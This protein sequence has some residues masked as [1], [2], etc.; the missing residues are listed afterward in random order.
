MIT[1]TAQS[2][3]RDVRYALRVLARAP[4]FTAVAI[5][6]LAIAVAV[7]TASFSV[8]NSLLF[9][10]LP[11][12]RDRDGLISIFTGSSSSAGDV[13]VG[14]SD[15]EDLVAYRRWAAGLRG[16]A[17]A[18]LTQVSVSTAAG[19]QYQ[20]AAAVTGNY[21]VVLG[22]VPLAGRFPAAAST[23]AGE[24]DEAN[25]EHPVVVVSHH[26]WQREL[27]GR[28]SAIGST[29]SVNAHPVT[30]IGVAPPG[31]SGT[32]AGGLLP[33][34]SS[35][36]ELWFPLSTWRDIRPAGSADPLGTERQLMVVA[37][38]D[39]PISMADARGTVANAVRHSAI[40]RPR[41]RAGAFA[42]V[43]PIGQGPNES[44]AERAL[45]ILGIMIV[46]V[47]LLV[48]ACANVGVLLLTRAVHR[49]REIAL[50]VAL[51]ASRPQLL[52][53]L[54]TESGLIAV[55]AGVLGV[56]ASIWAADL[57]GAFG[58]ALPYPL[59]IDGR[60]ML[61]ATAATIGVA[62]LSG[63]APALRVVEHTPVG[64]LAEG[65]S[66]IGGGRS[67]LRNVLVITQVALS[68]TL[69]ACSGLFVRSARASRAVGAA[70]IPDDLV[71]VALDL[72]PLRLDDVRSRLL[73]NSIVE[74]VSAI[75]GAAVVGLANAL[76]FDGLPEV[77][78][79]LPR[80]DATHGPWIKSMVVDP[81]YF[82]ARGITATLGRVLDARDDARG[83]VAVVINSLLAGQLWPR[84]N[85]VGRQLRVVDEGRER[86]AQ[87][88]GVVP[89]IAV[90]AER[91]PDPMLFRA[92][93][94]TDV[95]TSVNLYVRSSSSFAALS[96]ALRSRIASIDQRLPVRVLTARGLLE[97]TTAPSRLL[98]TG[99]GSIG[100]VTL[101]LVA[102]G[103][104]AT[105]SFTVSRRIREFGIRSALGASPA[106]TAR[107]VLRHSA[108][109]VGLGVLIGTALAAGV[110]LLIRRVLFGISPLDPLTFITTAAVLLGVAMAASVLPVRQATRVDPM[111]A[112]RTD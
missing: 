71:L 31:F 37:R 13:V 107:L 83:A 66:S 85:A 45:A 1:H 20:S 50:R 33:G 109:L 43:R 99:I 4:G 69:L 25:V 53:Q 64:A 79:A 6:S 86:L 65:T 60:V 10:P 30:V 23:D 96:S 103:L 105:L 106:N 57:L 36:A 76:P 104:Y 35:A 95:P 52:L 26:F 62:I 108:R 67:R 92:L 84:Q 102:A 111:E 9:R 100:M 74:R 88:I 90:S 18:M 97:R 51:G 32:H 27:G 14:P 28:A 42:L 22:T 59:S 7:N 73:L 61:F 24:V 68:L 11:G 38:L 72:S 17:G 46:P 112:L 56:L 77:R 34:E 39:E 94:Q 3:S 8:L 2:I 48:V 40:A 87:V 16:V 21:F 49:E 81:G 5:C 101:V 70:A 47:L 54:M 78:I 58:I 41:T 75:P 29:I 98:A 63:L 12:V 82:R 19:A 55:G 110:S 15:F 91:E 80:D 89:T 44:A 93:A